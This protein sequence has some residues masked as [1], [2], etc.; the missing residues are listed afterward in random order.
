MNITFNTDDNTK[1]YTLTKSENYGY[2]LS[3]TRKRTQEELDEMFNSGITKGKLVKEWTTPLSTFH[4]S[5]EQ[6]VDKLIWYDENG[7]TLQDVIDSH[8]RIVQ[9]IKETIQ[10]EAT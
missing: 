1:K 7:L 9:Q 4:A 3:V 8:S 5:L 2:T 10:N 6:V